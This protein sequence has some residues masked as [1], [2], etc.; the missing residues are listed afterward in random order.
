M[1]RV[2]PILYPEC[3]PTDKNQAALAESNFPMQILIAFYTIDQSIFLGLNNL[4]GKLHMELPELSGQTS[5]PESS[6]ATQRP[7]PCF[8]YNL[9]PS[10]LSYSKILNSEFLTK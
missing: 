1:T 5:N 3:T 9:S 4:S 7:S 6:P 10:L 2:P 8:S